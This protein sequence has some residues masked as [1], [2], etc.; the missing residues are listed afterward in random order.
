MHDWGYFAEPEEKLDGRAVECARGKVVGG[1]S[2]INAMA[3]VRGHRADYERW[4]AAG[5]ASWSYD[6]VLPY[7][8]RGEAWEGGESGGGEVEPPPEPEDPCGGVTYEGECSSSREVTWCEGGEVKTM[9]CTG[10]KR[11]KLNQAAGYYDCL[12]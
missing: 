8:K 9:R 11:C 6:K 1:S 5:L 3:Y 4:A 12:R 7:F 10:Q 2:S